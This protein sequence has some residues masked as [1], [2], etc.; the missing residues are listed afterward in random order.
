MCVTGMVCDRY[1]HK[2]L[3]QI[4][5]QISAVKKYTYIKRKTRISLHFLT[6][7]GNATR[8]VDYVKIGKKEVKSFQKK[9][10]F[11]RN[12]SIF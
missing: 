10:D 11:S 7:Q 3:R 2:G 12:I 4:Q 1:V 6:R 5:F 8:S 9:F